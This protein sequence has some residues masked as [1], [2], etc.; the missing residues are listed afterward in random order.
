MPTPQNQLVRRYQ[1]LLGLE[2]AAAR[3]AD[4]R[5]RDVT[6]GALGLVDTVPGGRRAKAAAAR[7]P[8]GRRPAAG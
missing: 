5:V 7:L 3:Q 1:R 4:R 8:T 2:R 6:K